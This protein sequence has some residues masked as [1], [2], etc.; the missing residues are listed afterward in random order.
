MKTPKGYT[1]KDTS[2]FCHCDTD[3]DRLMCLSDRLERR[4]GGAA[5]ARDTVAKALVEEDL[6]PFECWAAQLA[7]DLADA[8][9]VAF[10]AIMEG[11]RTQRILL[12]LRRRKETKL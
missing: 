12:A 4:L 10:R 11:W 5:S 1:T 8:P 3:A 9:P 7:L 6:P 2:Q